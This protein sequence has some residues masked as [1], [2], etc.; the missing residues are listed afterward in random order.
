MV[1]DWPWIVAGL[2]LAVALQFG[3]GIYRDR[4]RKDVRFGF[5]R[6]IYRDRH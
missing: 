2:A 4:H 6:G 1:H 3:W 5:F